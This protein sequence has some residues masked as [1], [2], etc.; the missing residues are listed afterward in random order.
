MSEAGVGLFGVNLAVGL[1][2]ALPNFATDM[3]KGLLADLPFGAASLVGI[4][5]FDE[6]LKARLAGKFLRQRPDVCLC[7]LCW[8]LSNMPRHHHRFVLISLCWL[9]AHSELPPPPPS[10]PPPPYV[11]PFVYCTW[12]AT[13]PTMQMKRYALLCSKS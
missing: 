1:S 7:L 10:P 3:A 8:P 13:C 4:K 2:L 12:K 11:Y 6:A 5:T 9:Y